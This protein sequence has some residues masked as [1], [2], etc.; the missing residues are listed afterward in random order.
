MNI[1]KLI[2]GLVFVSLCSAQINI[3]GTVIDESGKPIVMTV[4][5]LSSYGIDDTTDQNGNFLL[6]D[7]VTGIKK[8]TNSHKEF[9]VKISKGALHLSS[10]CNSKINITAYNLKG[11][12]IFKIKKPIK[13]GY[14]SIP[15]PKHS[16]VSLYQIRMGGS[17][18]VIKG[19]CIGKS[20]SS[21]MSN[22][23]NQVATAYSPFAI[24]A[25]KGGYFDCS[26][27]ISNIDTSGVK[28]VLTKN[29]DVVAD[30]DGNVYGIYH[31]AGMCWTGNLRTTRYIDGTKIPNVEDKVEWRK[32]TTHAY[33]CHEK[34][35]GKD[36]LYTFGLLYNWHVVDPDNKHKIAPGG[37]RVPTVDDFIAMAD[38]LVEN[39]FCWD[40]S[41]DKYKIAKALASMEH[42][43]EPDFS[44]IQNP[45]SLGTIGKDLSIN[46]R[47]GFTAQPASH[48]GSNGMDCPIGYNACLWS[49]SE[50]DNRSAHVGYLMH[51]SDMFIAKAISEKRSGYSIRLIKE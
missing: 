33:G 25:K 34:V 20:F 42:W 29:P 12:V 13:T 35:S 28:I 15:L 18:I 30:A 49:T 8:V 16:G 10:K 48:R 27:P 11:S 47:S 50:I 7:G 23:N 38:Y 22:N 45:D 6:S 19:G 43:I 9:S 24:K 46:N 1:Q 21:F 40:G 3:S 4:V 2:V 31:V 26:V 32:T 51:E 39:G 37:W 41:K 14:N 36:S 44:V 17:S 5:N